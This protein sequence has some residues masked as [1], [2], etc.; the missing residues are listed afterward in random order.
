MSYELIFLKL[1]GSL[2]TEK[3]R[4]STPRLD[5]IERLANEICKGLEEAPDV[6]LIL[7][8]GSGSFGHVPAKKHN[9]RAGVKSE[10]EWDGFVEVWNQASALNRIMMGAMSRAGV[11]A[12]CFPPSACVMADGGRVA[13][14]NLTPIS[15]ALNAGLVPVVYGDTVFDKKLGG[16]ILS[17][18]ELF[19]HLASELKPSRLLLAGDETGIYEDFSRK[20]NIIGEISSE[21]FESVS[22][23]IGVAAGTDVTG[24][25]QGKVKA[26]MDLIQTL[27]N[28]EVSIFSGLETG[29]VT[30]VMR[31]ERFGTVLRF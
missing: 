25:M 16:T 30:R 1:G 17:T 7:G 2:I 9:T 27:P 22:A 5:V 14:W 28:L 8:H 11:K 21:N 31:G 24:G 18:E 13:E 20:Q 23:Q 19:T 3:S 15:A 12:I 29:S 6:R 10:A 4:V 26:M